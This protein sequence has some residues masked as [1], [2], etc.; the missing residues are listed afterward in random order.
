MACNEYSCG[1][2]GWSGPL[3]GDPNNNA[4]LSAVGVSG[5]IDVSWTYPTH[6]SYAVAHTLLYRGTSSDFDHA[7]QLTVCGGSYFHDTGATDTEQVYSYWIRI[8]SINGTP[9]ELIGPASARPLSLAQDIL[10]QLTG[11]IDAGV[12]ATELRTHIERITDV[13]KTVEQEIADRLARDAVLADA[14]NAVQS[15]TQEAMTYIRDEITQRTSGDE[16]LLDSVN[17]LAVGLAG[18]TAALTDEKIARATADSATSSRISNTFAAT[19]KALGAAIESTTVTAEADAALVSAMQN[20]AAKVT[21]AEAAL[22]TETTLRTNADA[23]LAQQITTAQTALGNNI[24]SVQTTMQTKID[25]TNGKVTALGALYTAKVDVNGL[26]GG[27]GVYNDGKIVEAGFDVDKFWIGRSAN[28]FKPFIIDGG[29]VYI[30]EARIRL[31]SITSAH[32]AQLTVDTLNI[33]DDAL[34]RQTS[35]KGSGS[36][37]TA[38]LDFGSNAKVQIMAFCNSGRLSG[39]DY[40]SVRDIYILRDGSHVVAEGVALASVVGQSYV[41]GSTTYYYYCVGAIGGIDNPGAGN[42]YYTFYGPGDVSIYVVGL[43]K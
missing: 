3:P 15:E 24:A 30:D 10:E 22:K 14:F 7:I 36:C 33:K 13:N 20:Y 19:A 11:K 43:K 28:K 1:T 29:V 21:N 35:N 2:G 17:S 27:F 18:N 26:I 38:S 4:T 5:G 39:S 41:G 37:T 6:N 23:A 12:L 34:S 32:I 25:T 40:P 9:G 16:A 8:I 42:H 31:A